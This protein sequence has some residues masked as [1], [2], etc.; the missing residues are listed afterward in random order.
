MRSETKQFR[1]S[2]RQHTAA[3]VSIRQR[4]HWESAFATEYPLLVQ[5]EGRPAVRGFLKMRKIVECRP[6]VP[7]M[8]LHTARK[9]SIVRKKILEDS[10]VLRN[11]F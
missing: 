11:K 1:Y 4:L 7:W 10:R 6:C 2:I 5:Q 9:V 8:H 3:Y